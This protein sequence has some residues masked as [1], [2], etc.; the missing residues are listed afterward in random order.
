MLLVLR[1]YPP[2]TYN[3][4]QN[5]QL[6]AWHFLWQQELMDKRIECFLPIN[7][8]L[9]DCLPILSVSYFINSPCDYSQ[10][11][12]VLISFSH[13]WLLEECNPRWGP[14][15][16]PGNGQ[17]WIIRMDIQKVLEAATVPQSCLLSWLSRLYRTLLQGSFGLSLHHSGVHL[18]CELGP[19]TEL[20]FLD[21]FVVEE[22]PV[23]PFL[24]HIQNGNEY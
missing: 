5:L 13:F 4:Y 12:L 16:F 2:V 9:V 14:L 10:I 20:V 21:S 15:K 1:I 24:L 3:F 22:W 17:A 6:F 8:P 11:R 23:G 19:R 7:T 18:Q